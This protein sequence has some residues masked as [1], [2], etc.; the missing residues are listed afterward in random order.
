MQRVPY[1]QDKQTYCNERKYCPAS[2]FECLV[3]VI[4]T[5]YQY[6][7]ESYGTRVLMR[8]TGSWSSSPPSRTPLSCQSLILIFDMVDLYRRL[9]VFE[10]QWMAN[11]R[12]PERALHGYWRRA[13]DVQTLPPWSRTRVQAAANTQETNLVGLRG[14]VL[15]VVLQQRAETPCRFP[16]RAASSSLRTLSATARRGRRARVPGSVS[17]R[18]AHCV[19][20]REQVVFDFDCDGVESSMWILDRPAMVDGPKEA[21]RSSF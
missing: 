2:K 18:G 10:W 5:R 1:A 9:L 7:I 4:D 15:L 21:S 6:L 3:T 11:H 20:G 13:Q 17:W 14:D 19:R 16:T 8:S 12:S